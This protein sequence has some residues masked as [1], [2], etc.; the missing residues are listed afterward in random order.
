MLSPYS[1]APR[2]PAARGAGL[3]DLEDPFPFAESTSQGKSGVLRT[4]YPWGQGE[5][6][7]PRPYGCTPLKRFSRSNSWRQCCPLPLN[8]GTPEDAKP[9]ECRPDRKQTLRNCTIQSFTLLKELPHFTPENKKDYN[10]I[11]SLTGLSVL[12]G[13]ADKPGVA[14]CEWAMP[15][16]PTARRLCLRRLPNKGATYAHSSLFFQGFPEVQGPERGFSLSQAK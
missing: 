16:V 7:L 3:Q 11:H 5:T 1:R 8:V 10:S 15:W 12:G 13:S 2:R 9:R 4:G 6:R 14:G